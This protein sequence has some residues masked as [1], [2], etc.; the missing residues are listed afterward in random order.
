[1]KVVIQSAKI[2]SPGSPYHLKRK[3]V[4]ISGGRITEIGDKNYSADRVIE[5][6]GMLLSIGW[7]DLGAFVGDPGLE[8]KEDLLSLTKAAAAGGFTEVVLLPNTHP[9]VQSKNEISYI[10]Q[11]NA[12]RLVQLHPMAAVTKNCKGEELTEMIDLHEAGAVAFTDGLKSLVHTDLFLKSLQYIQKFDGLLID[13]AE[14]HWLNLFGQMHEG[15]TS[16][17]LGLK[18]MPRIAEE[19]AVRKNLELLEYAGG[20]LHFSRISTARTVDLIRSA[21]KKGM[22]VSCDVVGY[23]PLLDDSCL[24]DFDTNYKL[25]PPLREKSDNDALLKGLKD[26]TIDVLSSGHLPQD[27]ESKLLEFDQADFGITNLQ[28]FAAQLVQLSKWVDVEEL[29]AKV[30]TAPRLVLQLPVPIIEVDEKANLTLFDPNRE[31]RLDEKTNFSKSKNS[32]W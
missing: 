14:D 3:N 23:Q 16:T 22:K 24:E 27:D 11:A 5:A 6:D 26:G 13:H 20:R 15:E 2:V 1:M 9:A 12:T 31:W 19:I 32:P 4:V 17:S 25:N 10:T 21:K 30:T 18:G 28:T 7:M 8:H 29:I